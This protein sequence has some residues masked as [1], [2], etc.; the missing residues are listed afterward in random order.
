[1]RGVC[2]NLWERLQP[3]MVIAATIAS[4]RGVRFIEQSL[5]ILCLTGK[6]QEVTEDIL[7]THCLGWLNIT[8]GRFGK[9][10]NHGD[11]Y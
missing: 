1:M 11:H 5:T 3:R 6:E 9:K 8:T 10:K 2:K 4:N 7:L